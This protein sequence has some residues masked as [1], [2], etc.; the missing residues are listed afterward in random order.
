MSWEEI[1]QA[2]PPQ[3][4]NHGRR[5]SLKSA[6]QAKASKKTTYIWKV[7]RSLSL[8]F[9]MAYGTAS[10]AE[11]YL[12]LTKT[13]CEKDSL[14]STIYTLGCHCHRYSYWREP[15]LLGPCDTKR[16]GLRERYTQCTN[17]LEMRIHTTWSCWFDNCLMQATTD[18]YRNLQ[19]SQEI[20]HSC[21][22][23][24]PRGLFIKL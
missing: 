19:T 1:K 14:M 12:F 10:W 24:S 3:K 23:F 15:G 20:C 2:M 11:R 6:L 21:N 8:Y 22:V 17:S 16:E 18:H 13:K 9:K 7:Y 4:E 5:W